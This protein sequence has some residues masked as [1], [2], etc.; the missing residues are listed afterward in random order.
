MEEPI[1]II[2][3]GKQIL[4]FKNAE[5]RF[6]KGIAWTLNRISGGKSTSSLTTFLHLLVPSKVSL[7]FQKYKY[8]YQSFPV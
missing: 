8:I 7:V 4:I 1:K 2:I 6:A 5:F 3:D